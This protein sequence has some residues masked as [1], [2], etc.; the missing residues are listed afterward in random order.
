MDAG[1]LIATIGFDDKHVLPSL[2]QLPYDRLLLVGGRDSFRSPAFRRLRSFEPSLQGVRVNPFDFG[3]CLRA[4]ENVVER[5][6]EKGPVRISATG[7]PK[8]LTTA[9]ILAAFHEGVETWYCDP[10]PIRLPILRGV[11]IAADFSPAEVF[12]AQRLRRSIPM[13]SLIPL[14]MSAGFARRTI[15][16]AVHS[17]VTKGLFESVIESGRAAVRPTPR[18]GLVRPHIRLEPG[19][20]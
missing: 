10:D 14:M 7:G 11:R 18:L 13:T 6:R 20:A 4:I 5:E 3:N 12:I 8:I 2:R 9:A 16:V 15:L 1:A 19:K 17:L